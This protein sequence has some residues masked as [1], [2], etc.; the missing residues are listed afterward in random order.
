MNRRRFVRTTVAAL[1]ATGCAAKSQVPREVVDPLGTDAIGQA[2]LV[3]QGRL[4]PRELADAAIAR[5]EQINPVI[6]ALVT[7][8]FD[9]ARERAASLPA[10]PLS[11]VPFAIKDLDDVAGVRT[12]RGSRA[13][14]NHI[15][16]TSSELVQADERTGLN[17]IG[18]TNTPEFGLIGTTESLALGACRNP[19]N[20]S[21]STGGSSGGSAAAVA[22]GILAAASASDGGG[23]IRVPSAC[24]GLVGLKPSRGRMIGEQD[25]TDVLDI[26]VK[27]AVT[28]SVRDSALLLA[29]GQGRNGR[30]GLAPVDFVQPNPGRRLRIAFSIRSAKG[31]DPHPDVAGVQQA[32]ARLCESLGHEVVEAAPQYD[33]QAFEDRFIDLWASGAAEIRAQF[34][35]A[36]VAE[37]QLP[38]LLEPWTLYLAERALAAP[39]GA[40][41]AVRAHFLDVQSVVNRFL[42]T[43]DVWLTPVLSAPPPMLGEQGPLVPPAELYR[44]VLDWVAYTPLSNA[45]GLPGISLPLGWSRDGLPIGSLF[46]ARFGE[47]RTLLELAYQLEAAAPWFERRPNPVV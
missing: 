4:S 27:H 35:S 44:R 6:N 33:G 39:P 41:A 24:C 30:S 34:L 28:R 17:I 9:A 29:L 46:T 2:A 19:W 11:G 1:A 13:F 15:A 20:T 32:T 3:A 26:S 37:A 10:G 38:E 21:H 45:L 5:A 23:S 22:A 8:T 47:E 40:L 25:Q 18:K 43:V 7:E 36:G 12:T 16:A 14:L 31:T 42:Q